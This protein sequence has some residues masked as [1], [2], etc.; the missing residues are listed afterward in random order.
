M[1]VG[2]A[3]TSPVSPAPPEDDVDNNE[4]DDNDRPTPKKVRSDDAACPSLSPASPIS[5]TASGTPVAGTA[6]HQHPLAALGLD[7]AVWYQW[8]AAATARY[9][10]N[11]CLI[12]INSDHSIRIIITVSLTPILSC[13]SRGHG[14][15]LNR[16]T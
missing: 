13:V 7:P 16:T 3:P 8:A 11:P 12:K 14:L 9:G 4:D 15:S 10:S 5:F 1:T 6:L 2:A